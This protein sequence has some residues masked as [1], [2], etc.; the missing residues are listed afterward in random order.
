MLGSPGTNPLQAAAQSAAQ[1]AGLGDARSLSALRQRAST[2]PQA[3]VRE[4][5]RQFEAMFME[6]LLKS[7][8]ESTQASGMLDNE[9]TK[10]GTEMLDGQ[11]AAKLAGRPGGLADV[12][13]RQMSQQLGSAMQ[14]DQPLHPLERPATPGQPAAAGEDSAS[15]AASPT[16]SLALPSTV[17]LAGGASALNPATPAT[18]AATATQA[19]AQVTPR[20][21]ASGSEPASRFVREHQAAAEAVEAA[22]GIPSEFMLA[23]AAHETGWGRH[24]IRNADGSPS[25]N[26]FGIKAGANWS[27]P[28][29]DVVTTEVYNGEAR[30]VV[31]RFRAYASPAESF[32]DYARLIQ[33]SPR[34]AEAAAAASQQNASAFAQGLQRAGY[35]TDPAYADKLTRV[36]QTTQ[37][38]QR[39][40]A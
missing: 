39:D 27:G 18:P 17:A 23:Q 13:A 4:A 21:S 8:R 32:A 26:L 36:I 25:H 19:S 5:A 22:S 9:G 15:P 14:P 16:S 34:Y 20:S 11:W 40:S 31:Q 33:T 37:R 3:T 28:T 12:I 2:D 38:L 10:L 35:A 6:Q 1:G 29:T 7:M 30:K 24:P